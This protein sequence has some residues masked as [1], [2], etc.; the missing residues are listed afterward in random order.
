MRFVGTLSLVSLAAALTGCALFGGLA[1][2][3]VS[4]EESK[5]AI[6]DSDYPK[7]KGMCTGAI[8]IR[9]NVANDQDD[10]CEAAIKIAEEKKDTEFL[11]PLCGRRNEDFGARF[12]AACPAMTKLS[13]ESGDAA[14]LTSLCKKDNYTEACSILETKT[15]FS[16]LEHPDCKTLASRVASARKDFLNKEKASPELFGHVV[17]A[18]AKCDEGKA[19]FEDIAHMGEGGDV[20][21]GTELLVRADDEAGEALMH[22][23]T[24]YLDKH[25]G[26]ELLPGEHGRYSAE[27]VT[28]WLLGKKHVGLCEPLAAAAEGADEDVRVWL[29]PYFVETSCKPAAGLAAELL[30]SQDPE[31]RALGCSASGKLGDPSLV[32]KLKEIAETDH[33]NRVVASE[34]SGVVTQKFYVS[35]ACREAAGRLE[36]SSHKK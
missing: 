27:H 34:D 7:L 33:A 26:K 35:D 36:A 3:S 16:D 22:A 31:R 23:F 25:R 15:A 8:S 17:A 5:Q 11:R 10:T 1:G 12:S 18:L 19:I 4:L 32:K 13:A 6:K 14:A 2:P 28:A 20:A 21:Y 29:M 9:T 24:S 30:T